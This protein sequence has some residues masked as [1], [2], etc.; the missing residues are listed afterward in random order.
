[1]YSSFFKRDRQYD[2]FKAKEISI[3]R[4]RHNKQARYTCIHR[5]LNV[6]DNMT[7]LSERNYQLRGTATTNKPDYDTC[8]RRSLSVIDNMTRLE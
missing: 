4:F 2:A 5:S 7:R 6:S 3:K 8:I 1:M